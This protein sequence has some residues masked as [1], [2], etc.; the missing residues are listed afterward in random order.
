M[1]EKIALLTMPAVA[2]MIVS[3]DWIIAIMLGP[4]WR[5]VGTLIV[6]LGIAGMFQPISNSTG[7]LFVSQG[8]AKEMFR[9]SLINGPITMAS[10]V[11]GLPW[12]AR[13]VAISYVAV[14]LLITHQILFWSLG[15]RGPVRTADFYRTVAPFALASLCALIA[16]M[17]FRYWQMPADPFWGIV[18][19]LDVTISTTILVLAMIPAGRNALP[20]LQGDELQ[21]EPAA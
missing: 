20:R 18:A 9:L 1:L 14:Q 6:I 15:R 21:A 7:W 11:I 13:G 10:I 19:C 17:G 2:L 5:E 16:S 3:S 12:G 8:R 4:Q